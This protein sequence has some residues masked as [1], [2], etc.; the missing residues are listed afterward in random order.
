MAVRQFDAKPKYMNSRNNT[1]YDKS[2]F[3]FG[4]DK[5]RRLIKNTVYVVEGYMD[6][7]SGYQMGIPTVAYCSNELHRDRSGC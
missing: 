6:A 4:L 5:A 2:E 3:L 7:I 1:L